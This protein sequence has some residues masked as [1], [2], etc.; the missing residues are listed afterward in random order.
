LDHRLIHRFLNTN[1]ERKARGRKCLPGS[2]DTEE[3]EEEAEPE[4]GRKLMRG[5]EKKKT[6]AANDEIQD[7][8]VVKIKPDVWGL[9]RSGRS[10]RVS[11]KLGK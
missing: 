7:S 3:V 6:K 2:E 4:R 1:D 10:R 9:R 8:V 5:P 11:C